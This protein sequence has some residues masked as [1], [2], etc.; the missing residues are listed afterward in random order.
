[1]NTMEPFTG[2]T[3]E[4]L[5]F[6]WG[7]RLNNNR[8]WFLEHKNQYIAHLYQPMKALGQALFV[9]F[10]DKP[11]TLLKV[12]RIYR[13]T[14]MHHDT[15]YK[16]SLC[17]WIRPEAQWM[18]EHPCLFLEI[19]P[20]GVDFGFCLWHPTPAAMARFRREIAAHPDMFLDLVRKTQADTGITLTAECYKRPKPG[21]DPRLEPYFAWKR[22][23]CCI[24]HLDVGL[25]IF[26]PQLEAQAADLFKK[27]WPLYEYF[28]K[29][30]E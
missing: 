10:Q 26:D 14:R 2:F 1:M 17:L 11:G 27:L 8:T 21:D 28:T 29:F 22:D 20:E 13:D 7:I 3:P 19:S 23:I 4:T 24:R 5:D 15:P 16:E 12:S 18:A 25:E 6:L 9:P 30:P